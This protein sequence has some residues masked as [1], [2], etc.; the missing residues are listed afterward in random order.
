MSPA[1]RI[2]S[3]LSDYVSPYTDPQRWEPIQAA[4]DALDWPAFVTLGTELAR[5]GNPNGGNVLWGFDFEDPACP[6]AKDLER[7]RAMYRRNERREVENV[8]SP[9]GSCC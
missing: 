8:Y 5:T 1:R 3:M 4:I 2:L 9:L 6:E 7:M